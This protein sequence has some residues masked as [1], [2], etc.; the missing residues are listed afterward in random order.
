MSRPSDRTPS[1]PPWRLVVVLLGLTLS[2]PVWALTITGVVRDPLNAPVGNVDVDFIDQ[3]TGDNVFLAAD[4]TAADGTFSITIA[5]GTYDI[6]FVP[7][8][9]SPL[10]AGDLQSVALVANTNLGTI[11]LVQGRL[12]SGTVLTPSLAPAANVDLKFVD[13]A[14]DSRRFLSKT[15]TNASGQYAIRVPP[16]TYD[17]DFRPPVGSAFADGERFGLVV[18]GADIA[19]LSNTLK[20]GFVVTGT[21]RGKSNT[22][23]KNV[24]IDA[25][26]LCT[27][28]RLPNAHDNTDVNGNFSIVVPAGSYTFA[29]DPPPCI[30]VQSERV[31]S[32]VIGAATAIPTITLLDAPT[33]IGQVLDENALPLAGAK[34]KFYDV[35]KLGSPRIGT[36]RDRTDAA[37]N[38]EV[39][40][41]EGTYDVNIEPPVGRNLLVHHINNLVVGPGGVFAGALQL[42]TGLTLTGHVTGPG[43]VPVDN[44]NINVLDH[45]T[46]T[47][48]RIS[49]DNTDANGDFS[50]VVKP[51]LYD[52]HYD[53]P[54]C[55]PLAPWSQDSMIVSTNRALPALSLVTG[56]HLTGLVRDPLS[57][58]VVAADLDVFPAGGATKLY[59]PLDNTTATGLYDILVPPGVYDVRYIPGAPTRLRP[60]M[61]TSVDLN[62]PPAQPTVVLENGFLL[63]GTV[64]YANLLP[65]NNADLA[66]YPASYLPPLWAP[67]S[68]VNTLGNFV[69]S[70]PAGTYDIHYIP[71][72]GSPYQE[73]WRYGVPVAGDLDLGDQ[74]LPLPNAGVGPGILTGLALSA[75]S[76]NPAR[77]GI[78][79]TF[80]VPDGE[81]ELSAWDV[82]GRKVATLWQGRSQGP[83]EVQWDGRGDQGRALPPGLYLVRLRDGA[84]RHLLRRVTLLP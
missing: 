3:C 81:A 34:L 63:T 77:A 68:T 5:A 75:P 24:D 25:F 45:V 30:P 80:T 69:F 67:H 36:T 13:L 18:A 8:A 17:I 60:T 32:V 55:S 29:F 70:V 82:A 51:G 20:T 10:C 44:V 11:S 57:Q 59:T 12:V 38:F 56:V 53:P 37:G 84:G 54:V 41:P 64:H 76:P 9:G 74:L 27:G 62:A 47:A 39:R 4:K 65:A 2:S 21:V 72:A 50:V 79:M 6:H 15:L 16:G 49:H 35:T 73:I 48:Q 33:V 78:R 52:V 58:P 46:R 71:V 7:P 40:V 14:A 83:V 31:T 1:V 26:D 61:R 28:R 66:L 23:L 22:K 43:G 42:V 19:G